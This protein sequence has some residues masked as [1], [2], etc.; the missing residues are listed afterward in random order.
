MR[1]WRRRRKMDESKKRLK[2]AAVVRRRVHVALRLAQR[3]ADGKVAA[4]LKHAGF[5]WRLSREVIRYELKTRLPRLD[6][7]DVSNAARYVQAVDGA[8]PAWA[9]EHLKRSFEPSSPFWR[10]H[11]YDVDAPRPPSFFSYVHALP[12]YGEACT[13]DAMDACVAA[14]RDAAV[15][16]FPSIRSARQAEWW[17]HC[18]RH[19][20]GH[21]LHFDSD[22]EGAGVP[23]HP[24]ATAIVSLGS[25][26]VGGPTL[27][28]A[29]ARGTPFRHDECNAGWLV[30]QD[31]VGRLTVFDGRLLHGVIPGRRVSTR[32]VR[33]SDRR[34]TFMLAFWDRVDVR[35]GSVPGCARPPPAPGVDVQRVATTA[36]PHTSSWRRVTPKRVAPVWVTLDGKRP[37][38]PLPPY[39]ACWSGC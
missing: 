35:A 10:A 19:S 5:T 7:V 17:A 4:V 38:G 23:R 6:A 34:V 3:G 28:T 25:P 27:V 36:A 8:V 21:Q 20:S 2:A 13:G 22:A 39:D 1:V 26:G 12:R 24:I 16:L 11:A 33:A 32:G 18:R 37:D 29:M 14:I 15:M 31:V 9:I 30:R